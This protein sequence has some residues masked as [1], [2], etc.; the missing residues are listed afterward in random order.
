MRYNNTSSFLASLTFTAP[1]GS[2]SIKAEFVPGNTST[3][4]GYG[5]YLDNLRLARMTG[6]NLDTSNFVSGTIV[7]QNT[8]GWSTNWATAYM[9]VLTGSPNK[10]RVAGET[11]VIQRNFPVSPNDDY[12]LTYTQSENNSVTFT[13]EQSPNGT[14]GWT[15]LVNTTSMNGT[16]TKYFTPT[17]AFVRVRYSG[18]AAYSLANMKLVGIDVDTLYTLIARGSYR[19]GFQGQ[20]RDDEIKGEGNSLNFEYRMHDPRLGRFFALDPLT[21]DYPW[22]SPYAFS[23][24]NVIHCLEL[25]GL[26]K[27]EH[28][29]YNPTTKKLKHE[30]T[31]IDNNL[32]Q[33]INMYHTWKDKKIVETKVHGKK[34]GEDYFVK[35]KGEPNMDNVYMQFKSTQAAKAPPS[36][37]FAHGSD[38]YASD[39]TYYDPMEGG[40]DGANA[41]GY[42]G[43]EKG[44]NE[45]GGKE[46]FFGTIGVVLSGGT[47]ALE[48]GSVWAYGG[49][50]SSADDMTTRRG[51]QTF[52]SSTTGIAPGTLNNIKF[53]FGAADLANGT[54]GF[55][56][57][58]AKTPNFGS[59]LTTAE[60]FGLFNIGYSTFTTTLSGA[61]MLKPKEP[62]DRLSKGKFAV[63][64]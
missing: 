44:W 21:K 23:E 35:Y 37:S 57:T 51:G 39:P 12:E 42:L 22:N 9:N 29:S 4:V 48:G 25:E 16:Q 18:S 43:G 20:E 13:V 61:D 19:Y 6:T 58:A 1:A 45:N 64:F 24:N 52:L 55:I 3:A 50:V 60:N 17:E 46:L 62:S 33:N 47:I 63:Q 27:I 31:E 11:P 49:L 30:W 56:S 2:V 41:G 7:S 36:Q 10:L 8:D 32:K 26:E 28:Y 34:N 15:S 54:K 14:S 53:V 38:Y 5:Y 59:A 40:D